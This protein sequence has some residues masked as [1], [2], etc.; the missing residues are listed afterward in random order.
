[1]PI[2]AAHATTPA[3]LT[4]GVCLALAATGIAAAALA[5]RL[6]PD[7]GLHLSGLD[8]KVNASAA[9]IAAS[10]GW[11]ALQRREL[12]LR[13]AGYALAG[14]AASIGG[15]TLLEHLTG[16]DF[17][18]DQLIAAADPNLSAGRPGRMSVAI[19]VS[20][21]LA[22]IAV[23]LTR[24]RG[25]RVDDLRQFARLGGL[26]IP[27]FAIALYLY[28]PGALGVIDGFEATAVE[29][30]AA[31]AL[32]LIA[33]G[34]DRGA[35]SLRWNLANIGV[36]VLA[37]LVALTVHF[38]S[39]ERETALRTASA[40][41]SAIAR[42]GAER[43]EAV[44]AQT[45]QMLAFLARS[46]EVR[47]FGPGCQ[48]E[49][50]DYLPLNPL[51]RAIFV[52]DRSGVVRCANDP[53]S[54]PLQIG[55]RDYVREAFA[56]GRFVLSGFLISRVS[57]KPRI[58]AA[59]PTPEGPD[60]QA[61]VLASLDV[62]TL[63]GPLE[64]LGG[65][66]SHGETLTLIDK[67]GV[68]IARRPRDDA[69]TGANLA[70][71]TFVT[72]ALATPE[73]AFEA[74]DVGGRPTVFAARW[75]LAG[76]GVIVVGASKR[77]VVRPV[78][79]RLNQQLQFIAAILLASFAF[80][81][82]GSETLVVR[83]LKRLIA[84]AG[85]LEAGELAARP[86]I[87]ATG[88]VGALGRALSVSAQAI[89]DRE[90]RLGEAEALFRGLFDHSPDAKAVIRVEPTGD[91]TIETWNSAAELASGLKT[92]DVVGK[93]V[94]SVFP[95]RRGEAIEAD[96]RR[97]LAFGQVLTVEREPASG[98]QQAIY[99][100]VHVPLRGPDGA[101]ERIFVSARDIS[102]RKRV[103]R[104]KNEFVSTVSHE[105]R[106][107]LTSIAG[108]L[109]LLS[110][111]AAGPLGERARHL[112]G[113]A[114]AN[115]LR[116]VRL[117]N[118]ILDIEKIEAG[119][120]TY[121]LKALN[122][123]DVVSQAIGGLKSY[124]DDFD[125]SVELQPVRAGLTVYGDEDRLVQVMTNLLAN[126][127][128]FSPRGAPVT[129]SA[130]AEGETVAIV[131]RDRGPGVPEAFRSRM[132]TK[133]AQ[134]DG[135]DNRRKGGTG[136]G[137][138]IV[139]EIVERHAGVID[140][141]AAA[142][143]GAEFE[144]RLPRYSARGR[145]DGPNLHESRQR[146]SILICEDDALI[147]AVLAEQLRDAG[148][149]ALT[150]NSARSALATLETCTVDALIVDLKLP[151][152]QGVTLLR[153]LRANAPDTPLVVVSGDV[154]EVSRDAGAEELGVAGWMAKPVDTTRLVRVLRTALMRRRNDDRASIL[155][156]EDDADL[157]KVVSAALAPYAE[158]TSTGSIATAR[159]ALESLD[160]DLAILD[161]G[162]EDGS[163]LELMRLLKDNEPRPIPIV[164]FS[165]RDPE[166]Q[167]AV[168]AE[169]AL[170]KSRASLATLVDQVR[171]ILADR[172]GAPE[173]DAGRSWG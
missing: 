163:G 50:S 80:G 70:D 134:A 123:S 160:F 170:T 19:C 34:F 32:L 53:S 154:A 15:L 116:L 126:A 51:V 54:V 147:A 62:E 124:A 33:I 95:G 69:L 42:L 138:A 27:L 135:S 5:S 122:V 38:A 23:L 109:G 13:V 8:M 137:L 55:D 36:V 85:R 111:G 18:M 78:D 14:L 148:F 26:A 9:I 39:A 49:L 11:L 108:S 136:L 57:G 40:R 81:V 132:F 12:A 77:E 127:I 121:E 71:T 25:E 2:T 159:R 144:V 129:V 119:R 99:E 67:A 68:V 164:L 125:A 24:A 64:G 157:C 3:R 22:A 150:A 66:A 128:K 20:L 120:M 10:T 96:L 165:A 152:A 88:E 43:Q 35:P 41:L 58:A 140:Y 45:R 172:S 114:R 162:V 47:T 29:T 61:L 117:I 141:R 90:R 171:R 97:A 103:E 131:V 143:G 82:L 155:H 1:M 73:S 83:P 113:I 106:T 92:S 166:R 98:E 60:A 28:D 86:D 107:P 146:E 173:R 74:A 89:E 52:V 161:E 101:I 76:E 118:D 112:I 84:Y 156:L 59:L 153:A 115:S 94:G 104:L 105:L 149:E 145:L 30:A 6:F 48:N 46:H 169:A 31:L 79:R 63:A 21:L 133:F 65:D 100:F 91:L 16:A 37:P 7:A 87:R 158:V 139:R 4:A 110:G 75:V 167:T 151:D 93:R 102:E 130:E 142:E 17:G 168:L 44:V 56:T 72:Q